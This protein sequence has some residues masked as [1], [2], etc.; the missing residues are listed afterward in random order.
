MAKEKKE[1]LGCNLYIRTDVWK[2][3]DVYADKKGWSRNQVIERLL[4]KALKIEL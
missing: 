4:A 3:V 2:A 1:K